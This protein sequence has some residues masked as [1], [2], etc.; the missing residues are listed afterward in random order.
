MNLAISGK[1]FP[2]SE[3]CLVSAS[4]KGMEVRDFASKG[5]GRKPAFLKLPPLLLFC[6]E[7]KAKG[8]LELGPSMEH[9]VICRSWGDQECLWEEVTLI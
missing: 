3:T 8:K 1:M 2:I 7:E 5:E 6:L 4:S 9:G